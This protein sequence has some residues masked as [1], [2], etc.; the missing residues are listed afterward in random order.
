MAVPIKNSTSSESGNDVEKPKRIIMADHIVAPYRT[1]TERRSQRA[2][3]ATYS[4]EMPWS[5]AKTAIIVPNPVSPI[6]K[7]SLAY[8]GQIG[9]TAD[10]MTREKESNIT[11][12]II[13]WDLTCRMPS[14][15]LV[16]AGVVLDAACGLGSW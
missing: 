10:A 5:T 4:A 14:V 6:S 7:R 13:G 15:R 3:L 16:H 2:R 11:R 9:I 12:L 1:G 8:T